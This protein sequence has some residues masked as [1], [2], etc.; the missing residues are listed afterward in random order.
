MSRV[1]IFGTGAFGISLGIVAHRKDNEVIMWTKFREERDYILTH[2]ENKV[3]PGVTI[4]SDIKITNDLLE[5]TNNCDIIVIVLPVPYL[6]ENIKELSMYD[7]SNKTF[8]LAS[9]GILEK[10]YLMVYQIYNLYINNPDFSVISGPSFAIDLINNNP[11]SLSIYANTDNSYNLTNDILSSR[12]LTLERTDDLVGLEISGAIKNVIAIASGILHGLNKSDSTVALFM[13]R[14][15]RD[16]EGLIVTLGGE[17]NSLITPCGIGDLILTCNSK[18]SRNYTY[19]ELIATDRDKAN[20]YLKTHTVEGYNTLKT[21]VY[22]LD[23]K[24]FDIPVI[25]YTRRIII[26]NEDP[27]IINDYILTR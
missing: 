1:G 26:D 10:E 3:L 23:D 21:L 11:I 8:V 16:L 6:K 15:I 19:G 22:M 2:H 12:Y 9:K 24:N 18:T 25:N 13:V 17:K 5:F 7:L 14:A 27:S 20:E 4:P